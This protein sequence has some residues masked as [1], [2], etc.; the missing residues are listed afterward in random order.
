MHGT[1]KATSTRQLFARSRKQRFADLVARY[2]ADCGGDDISE[3]VRSYIRRISFIEC[4]L[5]DLEQEYVNRGSSSPKERTEYAKLT[6]TQSKL[7]R[8][9]GLINASPQSDDDADDDLDSID[10]A[11]RARSRP[12]TSRPIVR[13]RLNDDTEEND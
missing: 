9:I 10:L 2:C 4:T 3:S 7:M 13:E 8:S 6:A 5:Q 12:S 11:D 1:I